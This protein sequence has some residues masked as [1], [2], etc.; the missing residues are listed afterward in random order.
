MDYRSFYISMT[1]SIISND[2]EVHHIDSNRDNNDIYNLVALPRKLH[3]RYHHIK[4]LFDSMVDD[5]RIYQIF[6]NKEKAKYMEILKSFIDVKSSI[7]NYISERNS[8]LN[9]IN[10]DGGR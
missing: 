4:A 5:V 8:I 9:K 1:N 6:Y 7:S 3:K 2:Y 10:R